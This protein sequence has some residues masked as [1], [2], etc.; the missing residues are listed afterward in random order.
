MS[1]KLYVQMYRNK[2][3]TFHNNL[4]KITSEWFFKQKV[5]FN[6]LFNVKQE[7]W[8]SHLRHYCTH[9]HIIFCKITNSNCKRNLSVLMLILPNNLMQPNIDAKI[10]FNVHYKPMLHMKHIDQFIRLSSNLTEITICLK[11][12]GF[13]LPENMKKFSIKLHYNILILLI[14]HLILILQCL[15]REYYI[16]K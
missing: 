16:P 14:M 3:F 8:S 2:C 10:Y 11:R 6:K 9:E 1:W 5:F 4:K 15:F 7:S 13:K 12:F